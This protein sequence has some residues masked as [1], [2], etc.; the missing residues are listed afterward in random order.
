MGKKAALLALLVLALP[1]AAYA[2]SITITNFGGVVSGDASGLT[3][4]GSTVKVFNN[5]ITGANLGSV[6]FS[7]G[8][9]TSGDPQMGG[10]L[11]AGGTFTVMGSG[12]NG[13]PSGVI[14]S[15]TFSSAPA[16]ALI[17]LADGTH[18]YTLSGAL[19]GTNGQVGATAQ[20]TVNT[21]T[22]FFTGSTGL[23]SGDTSITM[24]VPEPG[25]LSL[26]GTGLL[27]LAGFIRFRRPPV[28]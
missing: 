2:S 19:R 26:F 9:F 7:T 8:A 25:M 27:G 16:W 21:G 4:N 22:G 13:V 18:Q 6:S 12:T 28:Q 3:L 20:L 24:A 17:T 14:F 11:A 15:G 5:N 10:T 23:A 1:W